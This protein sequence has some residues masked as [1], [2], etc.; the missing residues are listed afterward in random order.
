MRIARLMGWTFCLLALVVGLEVRVGSGQSAASGREPAAAPRVPAH[1]R[2][3]SGEAAQRGGALENRLA[4]LLRVGDVAQA[5]EA[6]REL[7]ALR[8]QQQ[9]ADHWQTV[10]ASWQVKR[11]ERMARGEGARLVAEDRQLQDLHRQARI[12]QHNGEAAV[13]ERLL[14]QA[15][16]LQT[17]LHGRDD[18]GLAELLLSLAGVQRQSGQVQAARESAAEAVRLNRRL[19]GEWHPHTATSYLTLALV[20][21]EQG[22]SEKTVALLDRALAGYQDA[23][24]E[25]NVHTAAAYNT[26]GAVLLGLGREEEAERCLS[27]GLAI[28]RQILGEEH[29][30]T[31]NT[32]NN[33]IVCL[34]RRER[35]G[36]A[37]R[38][39]KQVLERYRADGSGQ[40]SQSHRVRWNTLLGVVLRRGGKPAEAVEASRKA[41]DLIRRRF[42]AEHPETASAHG[43]LALAW[44]A[45]G[46]LTEAAREAERQRTLIADHFGRFHPQYLQATRLLG[47]I[48]IRRGDW[49]SAQA[50]FAEA[51]RSWSVVRFLPQADALYPDE[52]EH[53][54]L[55]PCLVW[56]V[57]LAQSDAPEA[58]WRALEQGLGPALL[59]GAA[60]RLLR[61]LEGGERH[62][63]TALTGQLHGLHQQTSHVLT[64]Q[65]NAEV[66]Q[67]M[68]RRIAEQRAELEADLERHVAELTEKTTVTLRDLQAHLAQD[69]AVIAWLDL[70]SL[71]GEGN[72]AASHNWA[73]VVRRT[74]SPRWVRLPAD[75]DKADARL[76]DKLLAALQ[77]PEDAKTWREIA[78]RWHRL[79]LAPLEPVLA[80]RD[81]Q[82][83]ARRLIVLPMPD[84]AWIPLE[85]VYAAVLGDR[86]GEMPRIEYAVSASDWLRQRS[87]KP[88]GAVRRSLRLAVLADPGER[89]ELPGDRPTAEPTPSAG[90]FRPLRP[91]SSPEARAEAV[92]VAGRFPEADRLLLVGAEV[93]RSRLASLKETPPTFS[94]VH[95][96]LPALADPRR[97]LHGGLLLAGRSPADP[98]EAVLDD[99]PRPEGLWRFEEFAA[100]TKLALDVMVLSSR[101][102]EREP[103]GKTLVALTSAAQQG[104][105]RSVI[106]NRWNG[107]DLARTLLLSRLYDHLRKPASAGEAVS[108]AE[109]LREARLWL[110]GLTRREVEAESARLPEPFRSRPIPG[111][112]NGPPRLD[113]RPFEHPYWWAGW[114]AVG[115]DQPQ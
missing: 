29:E 81:G 1:R 97:T 55:S 23:L 56:A 38:L 12:A 10:D 107:D 61:R 77:R 99:S 30:N 28:R 39:L 79:R 114:V 20:L 89:S 110:R 13:A 3:L 4:N 103:T 7:H 96:A 6:A 90:F 113:D 51:A 83:A 87:V 15:M 40:D 57:S 16:E 102:L 41:L 33:L 9:G 104:G 31:L 66:R 94:L 65:A 37:E 72:E 115:A 44:F 27:Q 19:L 68:L 73:C 88:D 32:L 91:R 85:A 84:G 35:Y 42:G 69:A 80:A 43:E 93:Q 74:G 63:E 58:A 22:S 60:G 45:W 25:A 70:P 14:R 76:G 34:V 112:A 82:P 47:W 98:V 50:H 54:G 11:L 78:Q 111:G 36:E 67:R 95:L 17:T 5:L 46:K 24:G 53:V 49:T 75:G 71:P 48:A 64:L 26:L 108:A 18:P 21:I 101:W 109:A 86:I 92:A 8:S 52:A 100:A 105:C 2:L 62:R 59:D 106:V